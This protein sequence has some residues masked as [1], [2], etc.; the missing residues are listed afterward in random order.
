[1]IIRFGPWWLGFALGSLLY[2]LGRAFINGNE[3]DIHW[4]QVLVAAVLQGLISAALF[5]IVQTVARIK[6]HGS[7]RVRL[8]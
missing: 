6:R 8:W 2:V 3:A 4:G 1:M 7:T 5:V